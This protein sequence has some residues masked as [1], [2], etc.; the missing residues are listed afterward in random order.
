MTKR[1]AIQNAALELLTSN[2]LHATPMSAI[3]ERAGTGMGTIYNHFASKETLVNAIYV[4]IKDEEAKC[5]AVLDEDLPLK[6]QFELYYATGID[7]FLQRPDYFKFMAQVHASP[8]I[9][10][11]SRARGYESIQNISLLMQRG[12]EA[13]IIKALPVTELLQFVSG[14]VFAYLR[15][16]FRNGAGQRP[17]LTNQLTMVWDAIKT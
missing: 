10:D 11:D 4:S 8:I 9:T 17:M 14:T 6:T 16:H 7:F 13:G 5:F 15:F 1:A 2:G 3:A 12:I